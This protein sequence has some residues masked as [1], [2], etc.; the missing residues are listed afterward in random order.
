M[1]NKLYKLSIAVLPFFLFAVLSFLLLANSFSY[2]DTDLAWHLQIG[3][4]IVESSQAPTINHYNY[5]LAD[6]PWVDHEWLLNGVMAKIFDVSNY[7][8]LHLFFMVIAI[9]AAFLAWRR[10]GSFKES[11][12]MTRYLG[13]FFLFIAFWASRAHLGLRVQELGLLGLSFLFLIFSDHRKYQIY[14]YF[15][16]LVFALWANLH[17]SF[18][19]GL[20]LLGAF[21]VYAFLSP[22]LRR[23][24]LFKYFSIIQISVKERWR[25][26]V[27]F[28][29]SVVATLINPYGLGLYSFL[30]GYTNTFYMM[31]IREWQGQFIFPL[32][33][34]QILYLSI[35]L[36][37]VGIYVWQKRRKELSISLFDGA[38]SIFFFVLAFKSRRHFPIFALA[39]LPIMV[40]ATRT[41]MSE[42]RLKF[43]ESAQ[44]IGVFLLT[45][46]SLSFVVYQASILPWRQETIDEY[47]GRKYPCAAVKYLQSHPE[48]QNLRLFNE[49]NWGGYL[50]GAYTKKQIFIDGRMPQAAFR[51]HTIL[52]EYLK[53]RQADAQAQE[54]LD[55]YDIGLVFINA[56][57]NYYKLK[58]WESFFF[59]VSDSDL[60]MPDKLHDYL[61][62]SSLW[63]EAYRDNLSVIYERR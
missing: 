50:I 40:V 2:S 54:L 22:Y 16:P 7:L 42:M 45:I 59:Q 63:R 62:T 47:C 23:F 37:L 61:K 25:L 11:D 24:F 57:N 18:L 36:T 32:Y 41:L 53:I 29:L 30:A 21:C 1:N 49:Y 4:D 34:S 8:G 14:Y 31:Y 5:T 48:T 9:L 27:I 58:P 26:L 28:M 13:I 33:Y 19:L 35:F 20:L 10:L 6:V 52:E 12:G 3:Q 43:K 55:E 56:Q 17:G 39:S 15:L 51:E 44:V 60:E 38:L 46:V